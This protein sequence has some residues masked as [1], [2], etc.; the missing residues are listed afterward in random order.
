ML[1][2]RQ[3]A[4]GAVGAV[5]LLWFFFWGTPT[6]DSR[7]ALSLLEQLDR[8]IMGSPTP[9]S[10]R[11]LILQHLPRNKTFLERASHLSHKIYAHAWGYTYSE[12]PFEYT[13]IQML[14]HSFNRQFALRGAIERELKKDDR[15]EWIL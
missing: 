10:R 9:D 11:I 15:A 14:D 5:L 7:Q 13:Q 4:Y 6:I 3:A 1:Y 12:V 2:P 8:T